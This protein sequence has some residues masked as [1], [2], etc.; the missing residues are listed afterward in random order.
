MDFDNELN[1]YY[2]FIKKSIKEGTYSIAENDG[3]RG[4]SESS[5]DSDDSEGI[6]IHLFLEFRVHSILFCLTIFLIFGKKS[7]CFRKF[8]QKN[9]RTFPRPFFYKNHITFIEGY[10]HPSLLG[11]KTQEPQV[12]LI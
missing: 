7:P 2:K 4:E 12:R 5:T 8:F 9:R 6:V 11:A 10:L 3:N 1:D